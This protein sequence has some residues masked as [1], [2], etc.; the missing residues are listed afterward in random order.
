V[1][2]LVV[3]AAVHARDAAG[4]RGAARGSLGGLSLA[5]G[6]GVHVV[7]GAPEDG[8]LALVDVLTGARR[9]TR[10]TVT[11][12]GGDPAG[13]PHLR[14]RIASLPAEPRL[15]PARTVRAAAR[16]ALRA[17]GERD[18]ALE[19][20]FEPLGLLPLLARDPSALSFA[21]ERAVELALAL[22]SPAPA[23]AILHE[24]LNDTAVPRP[25]LV[26]ARLRALAEAG[27]AVVVTT[28]SPADAVALGA[29]VHVLH[30]G[31][32]AR[33]AGDDGLTLPAPTELCAWVRGDARA[34]CAALAVHPD[35][36]AVSWE[37]GAVRVR[38]AD[39]DRTAL[40]LTDGI[41]AS[42]VEVDGIERRSPALGEVR[43]ATEVLWRM[44]RLPV[45]APAPAPAPSPPPPGDAT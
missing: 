19:T 14:A 29:R 33:T 12:A 15:P 28:S 30:R 36:D 5:L 10:G 24:P 6:P 26:A 39:P 34:L 43:A 22:S 44:A 42:G 25:A 40:A 38:G 20:A 27:A 8:T 11:V 45:V 7:L 35:L 32:L 37:D 9:P 4:P 23:L 41:L 17:R 31:L 16:L 21:E 2:P 3:L 18:G 13:A 1:T